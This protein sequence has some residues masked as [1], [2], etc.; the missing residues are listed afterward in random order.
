MHILPL[1][2]L[3]MPFMRNLQTSALSREK[4]LSLL[5]VSETFSVQCPK[6]CEEVSF[7]A[8]SLTVLREESHSSFILMRTFRL[9]D[10]K[11]PSLK[12]TALMLLWATFLSVTT[13]YPTRTMIS[14]SSIFTI[15]SL[16]SLSTRFDPAV[17]LPLLP[18]RE[19]WI[20]KTPKCVSILHRERSFWVQSVCLTMLLRLTQEQR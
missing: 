8:L 16:R 13:S 20:R 17:C 14:T 5:W 2:L 9:R 1:P 18:Q 4:S 7:T 15:I 3:S 19:Q 6:K 10:L 12:M 11:R